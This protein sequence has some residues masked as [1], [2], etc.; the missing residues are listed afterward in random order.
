MVTIRLQRYSDNGHWRF[1]GPSRCL[2]LVGGKM[3]V[4]GA[5][6]DL[7]VAEELRP[8]AGMIGLRAGARGC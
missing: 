7:C 3:G 4:A 8:R 1:D 2:Y 6:S 5:G